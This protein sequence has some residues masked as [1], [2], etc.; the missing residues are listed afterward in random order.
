MQALYPD[1][2]QSVIENLP[3]RA[4][5]LGIQEGSSGCKLR[6]RF[7]LKLRLPI[8]N[9]GSAADPHRARCGRAKVEVTWGPPR[10]RLLV[11]RGWM[12]T[13][14]VQRNLF[15]VAAGHGYLLRP[16]EQH[17]R[18]RAVIGAT[19]SLAAEKLAH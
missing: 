13:E 12:S 4:V 2:K 10:C 1:S 9:G 17:A 16:T 19:F 5:L 15:W 8:G 7:W 18:F 11:G 3:E 14:E 6:V